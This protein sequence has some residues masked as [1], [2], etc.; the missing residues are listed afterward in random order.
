MLAT[1]TSLIRDTFR[2]A[3][4][5]GL[6]AVLWAVTIAATAACLTAQTT[7]ELHFKAAATDELQVL[8]PTDRD[9]KHALA[10]SHKTVKVIDA[11]LS[12][13]FGK[14]QIPLS[15]D[16]A[17]GVR[18]IHYILAS[19]V[20][21]TLGVL[22]ALIWTAG[23][24]PAF[25]HPSAVTV[26]LAKP[27]PRWQLLAG[28]TLGV[29]A[30]VALHSTAFVVLTWA[31]LGVRTNV[32]GTSYLASAPLLLIQFAA[33]FGFSAVLA[34]FFRSTVVCV[35]G[36]IGCWFV[37]TAINYSHHALT[38]API[39]Q[40]QDD[41]KREALKTALTRQAIEAAKPRPDPMKIPQLG[42]DGKVINE[43]KKPESAAEL[44]NSELPDLPPASRPAAT[45]SA[46]RS[47]L[48]GV[49]WI[50]PKPVDFGFLIYR[51]IDAQGLV[52]APTYYDEMV[53]NDLVDLRWSVAT[54][55]LF[56]AFM[57]FAAV[58]QFQSSDY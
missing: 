41:T 17:D 6:N 54:S 12:L 19:R 51:N 21:E 16:V 28:K 43:V 31:A 49:Y 56:A 52:A 4:A 11:R 29:L 35:I 9:A 39:L 27:T 25:L 44:Y 58:Q 36:V 22:L 20:A 7:G 53:G 50:L 34:T 48:K 42:P 55:V 15:R 13:L 8:P 24:L 14:I 38:V 2:Q 10:D 57:L 1:M 30:F 37:C 5:S 32:W 3:R 45:A 23:F 18:W 46:L 47:V 40:A 33:F 26:L